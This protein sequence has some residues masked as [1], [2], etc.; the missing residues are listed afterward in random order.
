MAM[1]DI[2]TATPIQSFLKNFKSIINEKT[3]G[4]ALLFV[5]NAGRYTDGT[6]V[7]ADI[8]PITMTIMDTV[9]Q[10]TIKEA[11]TALIQS[12][13]KALLDG[14]MV[15]KIPIFD[16]RQTSYSV[17]IQSSIGT[18]NNINN[19]FFGQK[20]TS[21]KDASMCTLARG[22]TGSISPFGQGVLVE[23]NV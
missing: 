2:Q 3:L 16:N 20:S 6:N 15:K 13:D 23:A 17:P 1:P 4:D 11:N 8:A 10:S 21:I 12:I 14:K 22:S 5:H 7:R 18:L 19:Y 9:A